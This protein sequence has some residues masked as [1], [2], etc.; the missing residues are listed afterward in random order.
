MARKIIGQNTGALVLFAENAGVAL[1]A[2]LIISSAV[3]VVQ[4]L[5]FLRADREVK[6]C[7]DGE[8]RSISSCSERVS[9]LL[10]QCGVRLGPLDMVTPAVGSA[11]CDRDSIKI[12]RVREN[13]V[14]LEEVTRPYIAVDRSEML[15]KSE[16]IVVRRGR[17][18]LKRKRYMERYHDGELV[19]KSLVEKQ[20]VT[21]TVPGYRIIGT[22]EKKRRRM[23]PRARMKVARGQG[24]PMMAT[25]YTPG[26]ESCG[27]YADGY[28]SQ[29]LQAGYGVV[30]V[31]PR[32]IKLGSSLYVTGYG[33]AVAADVGGAI[34][35]NRIDLCFDDVDEAMDYGRKKVKVYVLQ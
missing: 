4:M 12:V 5:V 35:R 25:A 1:A 9:V 30:A 16:V 8:R 28:T 31:D 3:L 11:L 17:D 7:V 21:R 29:G 2:A 22:S 26:A 18:G 14:E 15:H 20:A 33:Y 34:K 6:I 19:G 13:M 23:M 27:R 24:A 10:K 32:V